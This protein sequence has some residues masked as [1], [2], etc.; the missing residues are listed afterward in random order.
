MPGLM[1]CNTCLWLYKKN[2]T[3]AHKPPKL[4]V[5]FEAQW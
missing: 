4:H 1:A 3:A 5:H 2:A